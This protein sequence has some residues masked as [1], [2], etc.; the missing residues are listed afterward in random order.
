MYEVANSKRTDLSLL[1]CFVLFH[2]Y[3][4]ISWSET[5]PVSLLVQVKFGV[6]GPYCPPQDC[7]LRHNFSYN[8][9]PKTKPD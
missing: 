5:C 6:F 4:D 3:L 2:E 9:R 8:L 7:S 1:L